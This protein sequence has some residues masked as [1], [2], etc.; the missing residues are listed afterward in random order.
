M[1]L[2]TSPLKAAFK[3]QVFIPLFKWQHAYMQSS[4][5]TD[6]DFL[7]H[8]PHCRTHYH[9]WIPLGWHAPSL[10]VW[11]KQI[12]NLKNLFWRCPKTI[13][14]ITWVKCRPNTNRKWR[15]L[16]AASS[17]SNFIYYDWR[18]RIN[19]NYTWR[20]LFPLQI[21]SLTKYFPAFRTWSHWK[22][23]V[24]HRFHAC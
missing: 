4:S 19:F 21:W 9:K 5:P 22:T 18:K 20:Q 1:I 2:I 13:N 8:H 6:G 11:W 15:L 23:F 14:F 3:H 17:R 16:S 24:S 12:H 10:S 7:F